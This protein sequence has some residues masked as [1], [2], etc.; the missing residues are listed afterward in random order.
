MTPIE[1]EL[2]RVLNEAAPEPPDG[3]G[4]REFG[5]VSRRRWVL[6]VAAAAA[7]LVIAAIAVAIGRS[8]S[9]G[10]PAAGPT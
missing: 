1:T 7:V 2:S 5:A 6:P 9:H 10:S 8:H 4:P 3:S